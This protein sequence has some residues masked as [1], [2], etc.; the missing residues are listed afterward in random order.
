MEML[1]LPTSML[2]AEKAGF[3]TELLPRN[4]ARLPEFPT[5]PSEYPARPAN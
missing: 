1:V 5:D 4:S 3:N 2:L